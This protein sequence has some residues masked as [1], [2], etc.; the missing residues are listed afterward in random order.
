[1]G[2]N[3]Q[4]VTE[5]AVTSPQSPLVPRISAHHIHNLGSPVQLPLLCS[6]CC[7][8]LTLETHTPPMT[9]SPARRVA[10]STACCLCPPVNV[11]QEGKLSENLL[12]QENHLLTTSTVSHKPTKPLPKDNF[13]NNHCALGTLNLS[14]GRGRQLREIVFYPPHYGCDELRNIMKQQELWWHRPLHPSTLEAS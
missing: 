11:T 3:L 12:L 14:P 2:S 10:G 9:L 7:Y 8:A 5:A 6:T 13:T 4:W 1:M